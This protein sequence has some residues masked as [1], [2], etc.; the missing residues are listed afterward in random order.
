MDNHLL[1]KKILL[2]MK[3]ILLYII[4]G[5]L[6]FINYADAWTYNASVDRA[7]NKFYSKIESKTSDTQERIQR[8]EALIN[9]IETIEA[10]RSNEISKNSKMTL[11]L[12]KEQLENRIIFYKKNLE[13]E[14]IDIN[15]LLWLDGGDITELIR[16]NNTFKWNNTWDKEYFIW[17]YYGEQA[18]NYNFS[19]ATTKNYINFDEQDNWIKENIKTWIKLICVYPSN[20]DFQHKCI[21]YQGWETAK[22]L[23]ALDLDFEEFNKTYDSSEL[24]RGAK[25][26]F[27][28]FKINSDSSNIKIELEFKDY[29]NGY[30]E[31]DLQNLYFEDNYWN[32]IYYDSNIASLWATRQ[33]FN[34]VIWW[35]EYVVY[36]I[37]KEYYWGEDDFWVSINTLN[38]NWVWTVLSQIKYKK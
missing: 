20:N 25:I 36:W 16:T 23:S 6:L 31:V 10:T 29:M 9:K 1:F 19:T 3:N 18:Q 7:L 37:V 21:D 5:S 34:N 32:K 33:A 26:K 22:K 35:R 11:S 17:V 14:E 28:K 4:L 38:D 15:N 12:L 24:S 13:K 27:W 2:N 8:V 30:P